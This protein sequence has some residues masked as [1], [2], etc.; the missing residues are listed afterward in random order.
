MALRNCSLKVF[1]FVLFLFFSFFL[2]FFFSFFLFFFFSFFLFFFFSFFLFFFFS[3][4]LFFF[5][6]FLFFF[7]FF[8]STRRHTR[9]PRDWSSDVCSSDL[10]AG[11]PVCGGQMR[12][13][14]ACAC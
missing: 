6:F 9:W 10:Q 11:C 12:R 2:F 1:F 8:S 7:F 3:F 14:T 5:F 4:F 13:A